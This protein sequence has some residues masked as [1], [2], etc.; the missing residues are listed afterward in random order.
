V[1][2]RPRGVSRGA[3]AS[4]VLCAVAALVAGCGSGVNSHPRSDAS[5]ETGESPSAAVATRATDDPTARPG[6]KV[7]RMRGTNGN[8]RLLGTSDRDIING[9]GGSDIIRGGGETTC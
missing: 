6:T 7:N 1:F 8:D 9:L 5:S 2:V 4:V 3:S